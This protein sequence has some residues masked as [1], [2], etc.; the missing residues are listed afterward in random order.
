MKRGQKSLKKT[1]T[2]QIFFNFFNKENDLSKKNLGSPNIIRELNPCIYIKIPT[3]ACMVVQRVDN[4]INRRNR[5]PAD[6]C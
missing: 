5:Y 1:F 6:K 2:T 4:A 3:R